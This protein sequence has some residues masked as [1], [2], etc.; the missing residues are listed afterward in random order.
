MAD[1]GEE[2]P[3][4]R[5]WRTVRPGALP[6]LLYAFESLLLLTAVAAYKK[7]GRPLQVFVTTWSG[8]A[9]LCGALA[10][11]AVL[12]ILIRGLRQRQDWQRSL[13]PVAAL[14]V[15]SIALACASSEIMIRAFS[16]DSI[17]GTSFAGTLLLPRSWEKLAAHNRAV[18]QKASVREPFLVFDSALGWTIGPNRKSADYNVAFETVYL[19]RLRARFP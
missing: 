7:A 5:A 16:V 15:F 1:V 10:L 3:G 13:L 18:L 11:V 9:A 12:V 4:T 6:L 19:A 14:N 8:R 2:M 17:Q